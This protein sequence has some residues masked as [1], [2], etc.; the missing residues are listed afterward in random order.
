MS[1]RPIIA[2]S[3]PGRICLLLHRPLPEVLN[4]MDVGR[5]E[6]VSLDV[7]R[8][9]F[10]QRRRE[11]LSIAPDVADGVGDG[12]VTSSVA[13]ACA[14]LGMASKMIPESVLRLQTNE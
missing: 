11:E 9:A 7:P 6:G 1:H 3:S 5:E 13:L 4:D 14:E 12:F 8:E 2:H 10:R